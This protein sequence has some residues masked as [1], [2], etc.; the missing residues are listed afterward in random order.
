MNDRKDEITEAEDQ[1]KIRIK[2][3]NKE[4]EDLWR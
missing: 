1:A 3:V 4:K 2:E